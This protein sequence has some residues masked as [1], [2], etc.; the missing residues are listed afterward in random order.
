[1]NYSLKNQVVLSG[2]LLVFAIVASFLVAGAVPAQVSAKQ[3]QKNCNPTSFESI[4][5]LYFRQNELK[6]AK[7]KAET[8]GTPEVSINDGILMSKGLTVKSN[9][10]ATLESVHKSAI[11]KSGKK[12][13][14]VK[15][16]MAAKK[17]VGVYPDKVVKA[18]ITAY[19]STPDQTDDTPDIAATGK[20]VY[21]GMIAAN[22]LP[23][24]TK[25]KIPALYGDKIFTVDDRMNK[26][27]GYGRMDIWL[28]ATKAEARQFGVKRVEVEIFIVPKTT[29]QLVLAK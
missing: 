22:W 14:G 4:L 16:A 28:D 27:Y 20:H 1:M 29:K 12:P 26:R 13:A 17:P 11:V 7:M 5:S 6:E 9:K 3:S 10:P 25:V 18:V 19:T 21:D 24:G 23:F 2:K 8:I 15:I